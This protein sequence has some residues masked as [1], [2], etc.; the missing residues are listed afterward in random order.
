MVSLSSTLNWIDTQE[1]AMLK[2]LQEWVH[3]NSSSENLSGLAHMLA[4]LKLRFAS[5]QAEM[6]TV[7][8]PLR[9]SIDDSGKPCSLP[10]GHALHLIKRPTAS[11]KVFLGGHMDTVFPVSGPFQSSERIDSNTLCGPGVADMKGGL[12]VMLTALEALEQHPAAKNIGWEVVINPDEEIGS[13]GSGPFLRTCAKRNTLGL[14]F[15]PSFSDGALVSSRKGSVNIA[16]VAHGKAAHAGRD[17]EKGRNAL[18]AI[19]RFAIE[20]EK[21]CHQ[22]KGIS[23]NIGQ[24]S[25]GG[26]VNIVPDLA[27]CRLNARASRPEDFEQLQ[28]QLQL[29]AIESQPEGVTFSFHIKNANKPKPFDDKSQQLFS[30]L[31]ECAH[32]EGF[33]LNLRPSGGVCD[34]NLLAAEGLPVID[35]LGVIGGNL[36]TSG[37]Y[38]LIDSLRTRARLVA[39]FLINLASGAYKQTWS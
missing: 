13:T 22:D 35:T 30:K 1:V 26:P 3:I 21:L 11:L 23:V 39:L 7:T 34:G 12:V 36:H 20:A 5:L 4:A 24:I 28:K 14:L 6:H 8:L 17:F 31:Q 38:M 29:L 33:K 18:T 15:E 19:A 25:G 37:E 27:I 2:L 10:H 16:V 32:E 9:T